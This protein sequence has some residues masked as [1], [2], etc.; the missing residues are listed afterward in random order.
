VFLISI[1]VL[2]FT[3]TLNV[4]ASPVLSPP[5]PLSLTQHCPHLDSFSDLYPQL[6]NQLTSSL[7][8]SNHHPSSFI[9]PTT[10]PFLLS[11]WASWC[12]PCLKEI[13]RLFKWSQQTKIPIYWINV[14]PKILDHAL[15]LF[16][17]I[18]SSNL[19]SS[20]SKSSIYSS[21]SNIYNALYSFFLPLKYRS[22]F[23]KTFLL[24]DG[25]L[26]IHLWVF[27]ELKPTPSQNTPHQPTKHQPTKHQQKK[28]QIEWKACRLEGQ[29]LPFLSP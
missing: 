19:T 10:T 24:S 29:L 5:P 6:Q 1:L 16:N 8:P 4:Y 18:T 26:P 7:I 20:S 3:S 15:F 14:N 21:K 17:L 11:L 23:L 22:L 13:P 27:P 25:F 9:L 2:V 12:D 28:H